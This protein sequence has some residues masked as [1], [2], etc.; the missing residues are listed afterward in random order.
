M[1]LMKNLTVVFP[2]DVRPF[3]MLFLALIFCNVLGQL[4]GGYNNSH[5]YGKCSHMHWDDLTMQDPSN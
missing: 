4:A 3:S 1:Q 2:M 5:V